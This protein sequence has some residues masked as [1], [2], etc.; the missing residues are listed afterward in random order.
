M[1]DIIELLS[2]IAVLV[3]ALA[4]MSALNRWKQERFYSVKINAIE[5]YDK[6]LRKFDSSVKNILNENGFEFYLDENRNIKS[7][8]SQVADFYE[9]KHGDVEKLKLKYDE[10]E[11]LFSVYSGYSGNELYFSHNYYSSIY[12]VMRYSV[13]LFSVESNALDNSLSDDGSGLRKYFMARFLEEERMHFDV[14]DYMMISSPEFL[15]TMTG[16]QS[17][18]VVDRRG[19]FEG[20]FLKIVSAEKVRLHSSFLK[21]CFISVKLFYKRYK[22]I[23]RVVCVGEKYA[24]AITMSGAL[25][26]QELKGKSYKELEGVNR[27]RLFWRLLSFDL[28]RMLS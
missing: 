22:V 9:K 4:G 3:A 12:V 21:R 20:G 10:L 8:A 17:R 23:G 6:A 11:E 27:E 13:V 7:V 26:R 25:C 19:L 24:M 15:F 28:K 16:I 2:S 18:G 5:D 14:L 1:K